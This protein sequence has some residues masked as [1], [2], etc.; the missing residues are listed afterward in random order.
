MTTNTMTNLNPTP[1]ARKNARHPKGRAIG[2]RALIAALTMSATLGGWILIAHDAQDATT[3]A[4]PAAT[5]VDASGAI[6]LAPLP[7]VAPPPANLD[8]IASSA[9]QPGD[10][11]LLQAA[12]SFSLPR[13]TMFSPLARSRS[14][15]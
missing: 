7:T 6:T 4:E 3:T 5:T 10:S 8:Q 13:G 1:P 11:S 9:A 14:S 2:G 12:P 15:N